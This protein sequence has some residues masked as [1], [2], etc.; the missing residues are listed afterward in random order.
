MYFSQIFDVNSRYQR[1][2]QIAQDWENRNSLEGY[3][4]TPTAKQIAEQII[5]GIQTKDAPTAWTITG[6]FGTGKSA[7]ALFLTDL[8]A[9]DQ[10]LH[11]DSW[12]IRKEEKLSI[13]PLIPI[14]IQGQRRPLP[15]DFLI[16]LEKAFSKKSHR[17]QK[18]IHDYRSSEINNP[19]SLVTLYEAAT[20]EAKSNGYGGLLVIIDEFGK[21]LEFAAE[22]PRD[23]DLFLMQDLAES[24]VRS[25]TPFV[26]ITI[27]HS[28][29]SD[30]LSSINTT[31][32]AEWQKVQGRFADISF[33]E[34]SEQFLKLIG[35]ALRLKEENDFT[36]SYKRSVNEILNSSAYDEAKKRLPLDELIPN[37]LPLHPSTAL[38]LWP[39]FRSGL[40]QNERSLFSFLNDRG[41]YGFQEFLTRTEA[42]DKYF[43]ISDLYDYVN[44]T[45]G[46]SVLLSLQA[47]RWAEIENA[48]HRIEFDT[49]PL[50]SEII[51]V[52]G[53]VNLFGNQ[54]GLKASR[55][56]LYSIFGN[57]SHVSEALDYL[58]RK[59]I[60][61][62]R[63][64]DGAYGV[65]EGSDVNLDEL[66][67]RA[68]LYPAKG[69]FAQRIKSL[70]ELQPIV[71]RANYITTGTMR[72]FQVDIITGS[73]EALETSINTDSSPA[74]GRIIFVLAEDSRIRKELVQNAIE[75]TSRTNGKEQL[76]TFAFPK[77]IRGLE[78]A[79]INLEH[80]RWVKDH[81]PELAGDRVAR[82]EVNAQIRIATKRLLDISGETLGLRG[83]LF[84]PGNSI[85]IQGGTKFE[86]QTGIEFQK[87]LSKLCSKVFYETPPLS[88]ELINREN[89]SSSAAA[90]RR[91]LIELMLEHDGEKNLGIEGTPP[92]YSLFRSL[93]EN[94]GFYRLRSSGEFSFDGLPVMEWRPVWYAMR[95]FLESTVTGRRGLVDLYRVLKNP[96]YGLRDGPIPI[97]IVA[98][99]LAYKNRIALYEEGRFIS[100]IRIEILELLIKVP[101]LFEV[102]M[103]DLADETR[104]AFEA[105][106]D[107]L[108]QLD[109]AIFPTAT[110]G[111]L[112]E[113]IKPLV[114]FAARLP[115]Y[116][117]KLKTINPR[118][119]LDVRDDLLKAKD[120]YQLL[121]QTLPKT[122]GVELKKTEDSVIYAERLQSSLLALQKAYPTLLD[123][124][125]ENFREVFEISENLSSHELR[126]EI[127]N[128]SKPLI[129]FTPDPGLKLFLRETSRIGN[130]DWREVLA[131]AVNQGQ[132]VDK[133]LESSFV[134]FQLRLMQLAS[135]FKRLEILVREKSQ[136]KDG[137]I[138]LQ[139]SVLNGQIENKSKVVSIQNESITNVETLIQALGDYLTKSGESLNVKLAAIGKILEDLL[140]SRP[141]DLDE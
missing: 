90:I 100:E 106:S 53:L 52:V 98:M 60:L 89:V 26:L 42:S 17:F 80:W 21:Y 13:K 63:R 101:E 121:F 15:E 39:L 117:R 75:L 48:L 115:D 32:K 123:R 22:N 132:P 131:R 110:K 94:G 19:R 130:R 86:H 114:V 126:D 36:L 83:Y 140:S 113:V 43:L 1:S 74:D 9:N 111:D 33:I 127:V 138:V 23:V 7:F 119:A 62:F 4:L 73:L 136:V 20:E 31:K 61:V 134:D 49:D 103:Y 66:I 99:L 34:P 129:G 77:P 2:V 38:I 97:L 56:L 70:I 37:C 112:L 124:I 58:E 51:K 35:A 141:G 59:S 45:I 40:S 79:L 84:S 137:N 96:P 28:A 30:Y 46:D 69:D 44:F 139:L 95:E 72:Y 47:R 8:L 133:W 135:D 109:L 12:E 92:E 120:P 16:A 3:L 71:A 128:R 108:V 104:S 118:F 54:V 78:D 65:W 87:W 55:E 102:Q 10:P 5:L 11:P 50:V 76:I 57:E 14:L 122:L 67:E 91:N 116:T 68:R 41:P 25:E 105:I 125:E 81:T 107:V 24:A 6:P 27:L 93:L 18:M 88:N 64:F 85:W 82:Q 29:F